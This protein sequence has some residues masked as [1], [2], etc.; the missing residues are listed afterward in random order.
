MKRIILALTWLFSL[1]PTVGATDFDQEVDSLPSADSTIVEEA[2]RKLSLIRRI[3][4]GFDKMDE[5]YIEPQHYLFTVMLQTTYT[6]DYFTLRGRGNYTQ[7]VSFAPDGTF[8]VGPYFGWKWVFLGYTFALN[9]SNFSKN[10]TEIDFSLYSNQIGLDLFYRRTG[11]D[12]KVRN[13]S[14]GRHIDTSPLEDVNF[15]GIKSRITKK[16]IWVDVRMSGFQIFQ[17]W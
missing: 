13:I 10:K 12:Y 1:V 11:S 17:R 7:S 4:R 3:I 16:D 9:H 14:L 2:P 6:Y 5:R 8:K 15:D